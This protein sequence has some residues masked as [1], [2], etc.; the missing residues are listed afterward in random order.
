MQLPV[1]ESHNNMVITQEE[2]RLKKVIYEDNN[3][4]I[5]DSTLRNILPPRRKKMN[6]QY[7]VMCGCECCIYSKIIHYYLLTWH[8]SHMKHLKY[9]SQNAQ[10][11][12]SIEITS[13]IFET[14]KNAVQ[15]H[16]C[17]I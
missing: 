2:G 10:N 3:I 15:P 11:R 1:R 5:I 6:S 14:N 7:K 13:P 17:H 4:T 16:G 12:R 8:D 9:G